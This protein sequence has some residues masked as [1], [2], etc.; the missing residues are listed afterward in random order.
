MLSVSLLTPFVYCITLIDYLVLLLKVGMNFAHL[1]FTTFN[2]FY[3][4]AIIFCLM[5]TISIGI[6]IGTCINIV[7]SNLV[8]NH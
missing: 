1:H 6:N 3:R 4:C 7:S 8:C 2:L 5:C